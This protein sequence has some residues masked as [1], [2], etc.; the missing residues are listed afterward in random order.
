MFTQSIDRQ[1][2]PGPVLQFTCPKCGQAMCRGNSY[3]LHDRFMALHLLP[4]W[5]TRATDVACTN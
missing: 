1:F 5:S 3:E 2:T 4:L